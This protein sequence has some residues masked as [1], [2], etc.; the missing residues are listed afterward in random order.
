VANPE[1]QVCRG[2]SELARVLRSG[3]AQPAREL[4]ELVPYGDRVFVVTRLVAEPESDGS[5]MPKSFH[6]VTVHDGRITA[7]RACRSKSEALAFAT[8]S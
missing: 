4:E 8:G 2:T 1:P 6:V 3:A 7:L 5:T